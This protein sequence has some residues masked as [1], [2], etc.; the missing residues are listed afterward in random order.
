MRR[1]TRLRRMVV[2]LLASATLVLASSA[3]AS[4][5]ATAVSL[6]QVPEGLA[7]DNH[8]N[9]YVG[10]FFTGEILKLAPGQATPQTLATLPT[11][12]IVLL[13]LAVDNPGNV[14][15]CVV[16][17]DEN[18]G[19]WRV[20]PDGSSELYGSIPA[21]GAPNALAFDKRG[22][23]YVS[24]SNAGVI[25]RVPRGG[26][27]AK[28]WLDDPLLEGSPDAVPFPVGANGLAFDEHGDLFVASSEQ[29]VIVRV[30]V[31]ADGAPAQAHVFYA[32]SPS[33]VQRLRRGARTPRRLGA[34][35]AYKGG[36]QFGGRPRH[37]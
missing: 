5:V 12:G 26:G 31:R 28:L 13:G 37:R 32:G 10:G 33:L 36:R 9:V 2:A 23:L 22:F 11:N 18:H 4:P 3:T 15:A 17:F 7:I 14:Y 20:R 35:V 25:W 19:V 21:I 29:S 27:P 8:G 1:R 16:S 30:P 6:D 24:D 34:R